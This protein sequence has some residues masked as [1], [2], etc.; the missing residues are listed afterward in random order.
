MHKVS[1]VAMHVNMLKYV[2]LTVY[3]AMH[4]VNI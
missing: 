2:Q 3:V 1:Y 4:V